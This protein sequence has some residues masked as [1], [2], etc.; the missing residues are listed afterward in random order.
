VTERRAEAAPLFEEPRQ[1]FGWLASRWAA[2]LIAV[3]VWVSIG[4]GNPAAAAETP[5]WASVATTLS[6]L[7]LAA[8]NLWGY[9]VSSDV[10]QRVRA[11]VPGGAAT[12]WSRDRIATERAA[13]R[14]GW[15]ASAATWVTR[16]LLLLAAVATVF[17]VATLAVRLT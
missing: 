3:L 11:E 7:G 2:Y 17:G 15:P 5:V 8:L 6:L 16:G 4:L 9:W 10:R 12:W 1:A 13:V 14:L